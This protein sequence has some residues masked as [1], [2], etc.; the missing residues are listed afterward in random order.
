[1]LAT[2]ARADAEELRKV[3]TPFDYIVCA[4]YFQGVGGYAGRNGNKRISEKSFM[5]AVRFTDHLAKYGESAVM[6]SIYTRK[7]MEN[8]ITRDAEL[9]RYNSMFLLKCH[10]LA[11][12]LE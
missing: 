2:V 9:A 5:D 4:G 3:D 11:K 10:A 7:M 12:G 6:M 8:E 1:M